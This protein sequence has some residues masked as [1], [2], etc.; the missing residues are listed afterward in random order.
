VEKI[1]VFGIDA[2]YY[3]FCFVAAFVLFFK[4]HKDGEPPFAVI[5][6]INPSWK[7]SPW[8]RFWEAIIFALL[9]AVVGTLITVPASPAQA[10][11]A[12]LGWTGLL[13]SASPN[14]GSE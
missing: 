11:A 3:F 2:W 1:D 6:H 9:G 4:L 14:G 13:S 10:I 8:G 5:G 7:D 12:G